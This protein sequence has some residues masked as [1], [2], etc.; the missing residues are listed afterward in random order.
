MAKKEI[1][2][3]DFCELPGTHTL[4]IKDREHNTEVKVTDLCL[5]HF[6][7]L[8]SYIRHGCPKVSHLP[9]DENDYK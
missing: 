6:N 2:T 4:T 5:D 9:L 1:Y 7:R 8:R 3:C